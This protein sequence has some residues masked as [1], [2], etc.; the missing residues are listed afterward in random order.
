MI[1]I[2]YFHL[3]KNNNKRDEKIDYNFNMNQEDRK[4]NEQIM[5]KIK[6]TKAWIYL[7]F[8]CVKK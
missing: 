2:I 5:N 6:I 4:A 3:E 7:C 8:C 1:L